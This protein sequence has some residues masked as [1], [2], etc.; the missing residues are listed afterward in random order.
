MQN[1]L[2]V[3][4]IGSPATQYIFDS[5]T[6][7]IFDEQLFEHI[8]HIPYMSM[9]SF[10]NNERLNV[11]STYARL[12][13]SG[14]VINQILELLPD[15]VVIDFFADVYFGAVKLDNGD[16]VTNNTWVFKDKFKSSKIFFPTLEDNYQWKSHFA[17]FLNQLKRKKDNYQLWKSHFAS[18]LNQLKLAKKDI[19]IVV[20]GV[21]FPKYAIRAG[22]KGNKFPKKFN[23]PSRTNHFNQALEKLDTFASTLVPVLSFDFEESFADLENPIKQ[24]WFYYNDNY[25]QDAFIQL[26]DIVRQKRGGMMPKFKTRTELSLEENWNEISD[27]DEILVSYKEDTKNILSTRRNDFSRNQ[28]QKLA[29]SGYILHGSYAQNARFIKRKQFFTN[30]LSQYGDVYYDVELPEKKRQTAKPNKLLISFLTLP[31]K[32]DMRSNDALKRYYY[33]SHFKTLSKS[34][35]K[36]TIIV[37]VADANLILGSFYTN[38]LHFPDYEEQVQELIKYL[39]K[40]YEVVSENVVLYGVSRGG[41]GV[42]IHSA[43]GN[44]KGLAVDPVVNG[45]WHFEHWKDP[46]FAEGVREIDVVPKI[47]QYLSNSESKRIYILGNRFI[48]VT[49]HELLRLNQEKIN[50]IDMNDETVTQHHHLSPNIVLEQLM[51]LN[52]LLNHF[53]IKVEN[54]LTEVL[55]EDNVVTEDISSISTMK[56]AGEIK[57]K[58]EEK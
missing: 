55:S 11:Q 22:R 56:M 42:L 33:Y 45:T 54:A 31:H 51:Y 8:L 28:I 4:T 16:Y 14:N 34:V 53:P 41:V 40:K 44:Y 2:K 21:R 24:W 58:I 1:T 9:M 17:S 38:T 12:H 32:S 29:A 27:V 48:D 36:D 6:N 5:R 50:L 52:M 25:Y 47:N 35:S 3:V 39:M 19:Q 37:R 26:E 18:F 7:P 20:N 13:D 30:R 15:I 57:R 10:Q 46:H 23:W 49:W 43:L